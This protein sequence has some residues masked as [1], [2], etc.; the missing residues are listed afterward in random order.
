MPAGRLCPRDRLQHL[1]CDQFKELPPIP[2]ALFVRRGRRCDDDDQIEIAEG[3]DVL[4]AVS[5]REA[6]PMA[7]MS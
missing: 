4:A 7:A 6:D 3:K 2:V 5:P 1:L